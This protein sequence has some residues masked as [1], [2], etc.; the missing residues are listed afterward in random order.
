MNNDINSKTNHLNVKTFA[1]IQTEKYDLK[2]LKQTIITWYQRIIFYIQQ[3][4]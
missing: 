1:A 3:L 2:A 4:I